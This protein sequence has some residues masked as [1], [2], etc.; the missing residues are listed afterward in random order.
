[1]RFLL[2]VKL[3]NLSF[4]WEGGFVF[5]RTTFFIAVQFLGNALKGNTYMGVG[6]NL[7]YRKHLFFDNKGFGSHNHIRSGD[8][9]LFINEVFFDLYYI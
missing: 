5:D 7:A 4:S 8:D 1:M 6:R 2:T 9:D 3:V